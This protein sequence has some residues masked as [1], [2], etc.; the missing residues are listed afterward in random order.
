MCN[1]WVNI[2]NS[3]IALLDI[4]GE[5]TAGYNMDNLLHTNISGVLFGLFCVSLGEVSLG[6]GGSVVARLGR[7]L[8]GA[9]SFVA[10]LGG[11]QSGGLGTRALFRT[12]ISA[13]LNGT[14]EVNLHGVGELE[15]LEVGVGQHTGAGSE[16]LDLGELGHQLGSGHTSLLVDQLDGGAL[17]VMGHAVADQHVEFLFIILDGKHHGHGL[18]NLD[19]STDLAGPWSLSDLDLHPAANIVT[20]KV[21]T[22]NVQH[23][24]R[25]GS[26]GDRF[27]ILIVP[28][29]SQLSGLIPDF[30]D[31]RVILHNNGVLEVG[32]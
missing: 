1:T 26:E 4:K 6:S 13:D 11:R 29:A 2:Q 7:G 31:L 27:L 25:E 17:A 15:C 20:G 9:V 21:S 30:L 22:D 8:R 3:V 23:V 5:V 19:K 24:D 10:G 32:S 18:A 28:C 12:L 16:V 14:L